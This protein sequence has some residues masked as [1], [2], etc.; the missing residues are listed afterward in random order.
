[1]VDT[2]AGGSLPTAAQM[3]TFYEA[4]Q[5]VWHARRMREASRAVIIGNIALALCMLGTVLVVMHS[6]W[7]GTAAPFVGCGLVWADLA[8]MFLSFRWMKRQRAQSLVTVV[9]R[10]EDAVR[11]AVARP[12]RLVAVLVAALV[13]QAA[14]TIGWSVALRHMS[15]SAILVSLSISPLLGILFF[16]RR[17]VVFLFWEDLLF[18]GAVAL[19]YAPFFLQARD[20]T[21][22]SF[23]S[24]L[25]VM[26]GAASLH[27]RWVTWTHSLADLGG[28]EIA[29]EA[30]S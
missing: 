18:A 11:K 16:V 7:L 21:P 9:D 19:A 10:R 1:M 6:R 20:L 22:L 2:M 12:G 23:L 14:S 5:A 24:L 27:W 28:E 30:R 8:I 3:R 29:L 26:A 13:I 17:F 15:N 25:L 4:S